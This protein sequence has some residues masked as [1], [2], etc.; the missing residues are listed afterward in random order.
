M[1]QFLVVAITLV[2]IYVQLRQARAANAFAQ[3]NALKEAWDG[4]LLARRRLA[5]LT[6]LHEG[7]PDA[8]VSAL[9]VPIANFW[10][11]VASLVRAGHIELAVVYEFLGVNCTLWWSLLEPAV[12]RSQ[13]DF[14]ALLFEH[15]EWLAGEFQHLDEARGE[16]GALSRESTMARLPALVAA[17]QANVAGFEAMRTVIV[18]PARHPD[19][20][21]APTADAMATAS[22]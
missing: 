21:A 15:Y 8:D 5:V 19:G 18:A 4:E 6:A 17:G 1:L 10:E 11:N 3:A 22:A 20:V 14:G 13:A 12:R 9:C 16:G 2:G 7:G